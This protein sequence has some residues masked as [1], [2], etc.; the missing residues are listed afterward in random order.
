MRH[1]S[2]YFNQSKDE[3][4]IHSGDTVNDLSYYE[5]ESE[6]LN[7]LFGNGRSGAMPTHNCKPTSG[8][9]SPITGAA[10]M[11]TGSFSGLLGK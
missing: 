6:E 4:P 8:I 11:T 9:V 5:P 2:Q 3:T 1:W 7:S 10:M